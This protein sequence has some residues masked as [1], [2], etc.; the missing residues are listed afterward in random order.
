MA[1]IKGIDDANRRFLLELPIGAYIVTREGDFVDCNDQVRQILQIP[2][3]VLPKSITDF[4]HDPNERGAFLDE[5][6]EKIRVNPQGWMEKTIRLTING[7]DK[8]IKDNSRAILDPETKEPIG[9]L[10][11]MTDVTTEQSY[12]R[13]YTSLPIGLYKLD[14][15]DT[16][17]EINNAAIE[18]L[19]YNT[20][21]EV[22]RRAFVEFFSDPHELAAF[23]ELLHEQGEAADQT[24][25]LVKQNG[26]PIYVSLSAYRVTTSDGE[27]V[28]QEGSMMD[29]TKEEIRRRIL[30]YVPEGIY[31]IKMKHG[32]DI[33]TDC[34]QQFAKINGFPDVDSV[35]ITP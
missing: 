23:K 20:S 4:Y 14:E 28:G 9:F 29:V 27:Y 32:Q 30:E 3:N 26:E 15:N 22:E 7:R 24:V 17:V 16:I 31:Q 18:M 33:I 19:G 10:C 11:C 2:P 13:L 35:W 21:S 25:E 8:V 6:E 34:N 1:T 5:I 12:N